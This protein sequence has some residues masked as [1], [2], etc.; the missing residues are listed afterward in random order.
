MTPKATYTTRLLP[1]PPLESGD[2]LARQEFE[3]RYKTM[4][5][6]NKAELI[7]GVVIIPSSVHFYSHS[8]P[9]AHIIGWLAVYSAATPGTSLG[10]NA[11][12]CLDTD[13]EVQPDA[14]LRL[15]EKKNGQSR[16]SE[17]DYIE[18]APELIVEI[19]ASSASYDLYEKKD[20]YRRN[21]VQEY[22]VWQIYDGRVVWHYLDKGIYKELLTD[23]NGIIRSQIFSGLW[24]NVNALLT[25]DLAAVLATVQTDLA[26]PT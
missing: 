15:D 3:R 23:E 9:H 1:I 26:N 16:I 24:L 18:G 20:I 8:Q 2:R 12:V 22:I 21:G 14:L 5:R 6:I 7:E 11:T 4:P 10:D 13:N 25:E 19:A 17:D